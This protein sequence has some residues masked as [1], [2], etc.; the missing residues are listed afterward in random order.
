M[1]EPLRVI[2]YGGGVQSTAMLVLAAQ[3]KLDYQYALF[4]NVGDDS[5]YP[6]TLD[7]V[8]DVARPWAEGQTPGVDVFELK[9]T[10]IRG[11]R[12]GEVDT[13]MDRLVR[14][15]SKSIPIPVFMS[16]GG[17]TN[18]ACTVDY[19]INVMARWLKESGATAENPALVAIG[20]STDEYQRARSSSTIPHE[21]MVYP[22]LD[23]GL[24]RQDCANVIHRAGLRVPP[25]S[26]CFFCP[27]HSPQT[28]MELRRDKPELFYKSVLLENDI[29]DKR[30]DQG[31]DPVYL[32]K[33]GKPLDQ[34]IPVGQPTLFSGEDWLDESGECDEGYCFV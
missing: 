29:N 22:L 15:D 34:A 25:K 4:A 10:M 33:F 20:I 27:F 23:L 21:R 12:A 31:R 19:K 14:P 30:F 24:S 28:W 16:E 32:T 17:L 26:S 11:P 2:A 7:Y 3:G 13:L 8:R 1:S 6:D 9:K 5:E 18:R